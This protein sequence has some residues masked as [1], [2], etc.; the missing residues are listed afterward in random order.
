MARE[1]AIRKRIERVGFELLCF[2]SLSL[3]LSNTAANLD[4]RERAAFTESRLRS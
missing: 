3:S 1:Y 2:L 4:K